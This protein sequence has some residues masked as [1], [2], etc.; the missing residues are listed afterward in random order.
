MFKP[1][2]KNL[3]NILKEFNDPKNKEKYRPLTIDE[4]R[5]LV[6]D[7]KE[8]NLE[9]LKQQLINHNVFIPI[10][11]SK[12]YI[13]NSKDY[14]AVLQDAFLGLCHAMEKFDFERHQ[15]FCTYAYNWIKKYALM[16]YYDKHNMHIANKS[17]S[18]NAEVSY[19]TSGSEDDGADYMDVF[20]PMLEVATCK[21]FNYFT[22]SSLSTS[23]VVESKETK[24]AISNIYENLLSYI[25]IS[26]EF[27]TLDKDIFRLMLIDKK[28][29][30]EAADTLNIKQNI[31]QYKKTCI[32]NKLK[33]Y[34]GSECNIH[35]MEEIK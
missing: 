31:I 33:K 16:D 19:N 35:T 11:L 2:A 17:N 1:M 3:D 21:D 25:N 5:Q 13:N 26:T 15:R 9:E 7:L 24:D 4:E 6:T 8:T 14:E 29:A 27:S 32:L 10:N 22:S 12:A 34:L 30:K 23:D 28:S 18:L 20:D